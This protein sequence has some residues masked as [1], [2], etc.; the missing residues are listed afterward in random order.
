MRFRLVMA[1][2]VLATAAVAGCGSSQSEPEREKI[3]C[4][5]PEMMIGWRDTK[6]EIPGT[7]IDPEIKRLMRGRTVTISGSVLLGDRD[8]E[9]W[10]DLLPSEV[11]VNCYTPR[12]ETRWV[13]VS[14]DDIVSP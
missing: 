7:L 6:G 13:R 14:Q 4:S 11:M 10:F 8:A 12:D 2:V 5:E 9:P 3:Y 1:A